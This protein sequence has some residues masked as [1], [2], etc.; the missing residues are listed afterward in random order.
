[1]IAQSQRPGK[2]ATVQPRAACMF[3]ASNRLPLTAVR[4]AGVLRFRRS[5]G[6]LVAGLLQVARN[7]PV[8]WYGWNG[9][10]GEGETAQ[11]WRRWEGA[12]LIAVPMSDAEIQSFYHQYCNCLLWPVLHGFTE[13][14]V[15]A[16]HEWRVYATMNARYADAI[17]QDARRGDTV[18][19]HDYHLL[20]VPQL[21]RQ[22]RP[23][24]PIAFFLHTPFPEPEI[25]A[26]IPECNELLR[27][28]LGADV[29]GFHTA[30]FARNFLE[31]VRRL[32]YT[33]Q[34]NDVLVAGRVVTVKTRPMGIDVDAF[35]RL[36]TDPDT[37]IE[38]DRI[39]A[40]NTK[41]L[42]GVDRLDYTKGI[43]ERLLAFEMLL[44]EHPQLRGAVSLFQIAVPSRGEISAYRDLRNVVESIVERINRRFGS[45]GWQP[46]EY[47]YDTIDLNTLVSLY[48]AADVMLVT[49]HR[50]G[51]NLVAKEF[52]ATR[53]DNDGVLILSKYAGA[54]TELT[55][56]L[57]VDPKQVREIAGA[58]R[59]ALDMSA[60][61]RAMRMRALRNAVAGNDV[62]LWASEFVEDLSVLQHAYA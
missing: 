41:L 22:R 20:L 50:D 47:L 11:Y 55:A 9:V 6:G 5:N 45:A 31:A 26:A 21:L 3:I 23:D 18:W 49:S 52:V 34:G 12:S 19:V 37:L 2:P 25:F 43:P 48:R 58:C 38:V 56:A 33:V 57:Q 29:I 27:G 10:N 54:A 17:L 13:N 61:E 44:T 15:T 8:R 59:R 4:D 30:E 62:V 46:V 51:L 28:M 53:T 35:A 36:A 24:L 42:L 32:G 1:M 39:R 16:D 14:V 40:T 7:W 60:H